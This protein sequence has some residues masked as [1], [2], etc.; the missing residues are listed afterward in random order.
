MAPYQKTAYYVTLEFCSITCSLANVFL[1]IYAP[2]YD[3]SS[4]SVF[5]KT[6]RFTFVC[7]K[8][9]VDMETLYTYF[10]FAVS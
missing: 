9:R 1:K 8:I 6:L 4:T 7:V 3:G 5:V 10:V 2:W